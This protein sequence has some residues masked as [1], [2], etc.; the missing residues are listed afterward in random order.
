MKKPKAYVCIDA[1]N[2]HYY[3]IKA[4]WQ[5]GWQKFKLYCENHYESP[6]VFYYEGVPSKSQYFDIH[7]DHSMTDFI[8]AKKNKLKYFKFLKS[9]SFRVRHNLS[10]VSTIMQR[11]NLS[12][13]ATLMWN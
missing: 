3:L 6:K 2:F 13:N 10:V 9:L 8:Q 1:S 7:S 5:I 4:G 11:G 12:I